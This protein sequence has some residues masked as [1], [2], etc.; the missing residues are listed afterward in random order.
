MSKKASITE[1]KHR[2]AKQVMLAIKG[3]LKGAF[4]PASDGVSSKKGS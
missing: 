1:T 2:K 3:S 4:G